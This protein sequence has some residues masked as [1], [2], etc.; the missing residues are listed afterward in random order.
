MSSLK[1][2]NPNLK[3]VAKYEVLKYDKAES[4]AHKYFEKFIYEGEFFEVKFEDIHNYMLEYYCVHD[5]QVVVYS[6]DKR[7]R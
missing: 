2:S 6:K 5:A 3:L 4:N 7:N 1:T